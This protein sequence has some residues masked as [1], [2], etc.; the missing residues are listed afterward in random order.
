MVSMEVNKATIWYS[1]LVR[2]E[3]IRILDADGLFTGE[4]GPKY[5]APQPVTVALS[6][7]IGLNN[8]TAQGVADLKPYGVF[9]NYT[10]RMITEDMNCP[11]N[12]ESIIWHERDPGDNPYDVPYNFKV[13]RASKT[14][15]YKMYYLRQVLLQG[16][17]DPG[18]P[19]G[20][21]GETGMTGET[22]ATGETGETGVTGET[23][24]TG[25]TGATGET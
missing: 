4:Y 13:V 12:E 21:T 19:T 23:G 9:T 25:E 22:G 15:N 1:N 3:R 14:L 18:W 10:H 8:L 2:N 16:E 11:I 17:G 6:E 5:T 7:S 20:E 24:M